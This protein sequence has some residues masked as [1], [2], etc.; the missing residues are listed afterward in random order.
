MSPVN[1][2]NPQP[3]Y[4]A[5]FDKMKCLEFTMNVG[6]TLFIPA[7][8]WYSIKFNSNTSISCFR[9]RTYMNNIAISP[10]IAMY[11]LQ[12]QNIKRVVAKKTSISELNNEVKHTTNINSIN[13]INSSNG[14]NS[15][16]NTIDIQGDGSG[17]DIHNL[18]G[19]VVIEDNIDNG[20]NFDNV[21][22]VNSGNIDNAISFDNITNFGSE[23]Q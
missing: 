3:K 19:P 7:Y 13:S 10:Y 5:S 16:T 20:S 14:E 21:N 12:I 6:Q 8:W 17:T 4:A 22:S 15:I 1:P 18:P 2:W 23:L 11:A 9:Y